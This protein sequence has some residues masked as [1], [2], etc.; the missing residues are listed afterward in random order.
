MGSY[1]YDAFGNLLEDESSVANSYKYAGYQHDEENGLY[2]LNARF[3]DPEIARFIQEDT[4]R[5][6]TADPLSL[7]LYTYCVNNPMKYYDPTGH[8]SQPIGDDGV[9]RGIYDQTY[10]WNGVAYDHIPEGM[11]ECYIYPE[12]C[13]D[14]S[15][16]HKTIEITMGV[17]ELLEIDV[18]Y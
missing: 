15:H 13:E 16:Q 5:G 6:N 11:P 12:M 2:Y 14:I 4:Y 10:F 9:Y 1:Y 7:N 17:G 8:A 18:E 3:Y